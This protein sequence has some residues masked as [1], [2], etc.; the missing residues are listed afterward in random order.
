MVD[1]YAPYGTP[2]YVRPLKAV[3]KAHDIVRAASSLPVIELFSRHNGNDSFR[4]TD[5]SRLRPKVQH[6]K[7]GSAATKV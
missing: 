6:D 1:R 7:R 3:D 2:S 4:L 5:P